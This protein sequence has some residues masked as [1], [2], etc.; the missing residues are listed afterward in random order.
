[1]TLRRG[2]PA[3]L[4]LVLLGAS[5]PARALSPEDE[6]IVDAGL[7]AL[8]HSDYDGAQKIFDDAVAAQPGDPALSLGSAIEAWWRMETDFA[9][10]GSPEAKRFLDADKRAID[11]ARRASDMGGDAEAFTCLG[12]AYGL[13]GRYEATQKH[14]FK[15]YGD[16]K[17]SYKS[18]LSATKLDPTLDDPYLGLGAFDYYSSRHSSFVRFFI[19]T[20][21]GDKEKG[22][23]ELERA[24]HGRFSGVAAQ[25]LL[26][27]IHW[28]FEK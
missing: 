24:T 28:T 27:G 17:R 13:R 11:D 21:N 12:A 23:A 3:I 14:W 19:F 7:D 22:L 15:A 1:M 2:V 26:V 5:A 8:Y 18:E 10:P 6:K 20:K 9:D 25:F 16:G 4:A